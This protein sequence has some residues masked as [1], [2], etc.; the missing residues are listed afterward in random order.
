MKPITIR[1]GD[2]VTATLESHRDGR[3]I[4]HPAEAAWFNAHLHLVT[5]VA[6]SVQTDEER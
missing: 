4:T 1:V 3:R 2:Y 6:R 5:D